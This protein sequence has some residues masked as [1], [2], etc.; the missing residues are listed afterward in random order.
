MVFMTRLYNKHDQVIFTHKFS[1]LR[2]V[3]N[4]SINQQIKAIQNIYPSIS[5]NQGED[6][7]I[8]LLFQRK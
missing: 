8:R 7:H 6:S 5:Q 2:N 3:I 4:Q 1:C